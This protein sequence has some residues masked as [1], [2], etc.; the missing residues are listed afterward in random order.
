MQATGIKGL[1]VVNPQAFEDERGWFLESYHKTKY[2][3]SF[4][5][6][7][8][9]YISDMIIDN[10]SF[11]HKGVLRGLHLQ[12]YPYAQSK[13]VRVAYGEIVDVAVDLRN[14]SSTFGKWYAITL[15]HEN[16]KQ[17]WDSERICSWIP[18]I[19]RFCVSRIQVR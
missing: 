10:E 17:F 15:S 3:D 13:L 1:L 2:K 9:E 11:S 7:Y 6:E 18:C 4:H 8:K 16:K 5:P 14:G 19:V 12:T